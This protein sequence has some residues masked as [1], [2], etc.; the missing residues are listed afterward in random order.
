MKSH[1]RLSSS[2][3]LGIAGVIT[4]LTPVNA[5]SRLNPALLEGL[6]NVP[7]VTPTRNE[8]LSPQSR[9]CPA[10]V[11][12]LTA[13]LLR[14][15]PGYANRISQRARRRS[16]TD[17]LYSSV[18]TAGRPEFE[19]LT[20]GPGQYTSADPAA[21]VEPPKQVFLTTLERQYTAG[22][23]VELQLFHWLF[24]VYTDRGWQLAMM[25][26]RIRP[27][28]E[29]SLPTPPLESS[30]GIIGQGVRT[31]LRDCHVGYI[32]PLRNPL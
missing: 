9:Q 4:Q 2:L 24:L 25:Y 23:A 27:S 31:W 22:K 11:E 8:Q 3:W 7:Q 29:G 20:L 28:P 1:F 26:S 17:N 6:R 12:T 30:N 19:P 21:A 18:I 15:L 13:L 10:D 16:Q 32:R 5:A 14:D